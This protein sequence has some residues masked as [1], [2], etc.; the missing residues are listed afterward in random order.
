MASSAPPANTTAVNS[1]VQEILPSPTTLVHAARLA[2][3]NDKPLLFDYYVDSATKK[4]FMG[5]DKETNDKMLVKSAEEYTS[6]IVKTYKVA[7]DFIVETENSI[8]IV[9]GK[10]EMRKIQSQSFKLE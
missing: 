6:Q 4:A 1:A 9:S 8:Y 7:E 10:I 5:L 3:K 2:L